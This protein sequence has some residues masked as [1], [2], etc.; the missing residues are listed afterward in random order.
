[1]AKVAD[2]VERMLQFKQRCP[3]V[4]FDLKPYL[5]TARVPGRDEPFRAMSLCRLMVAI[6][7]WAAEQT[8]ARLLFGAGPADRQGTADDRLPVLMRVRHR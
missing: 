6:E 5:F 1:M 4:E 2:R 3:D 7:R 8:I